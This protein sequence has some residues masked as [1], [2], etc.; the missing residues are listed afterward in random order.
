LLSPFDPLIHDRS[1]TRKVFGFDYTVEIFVPATK[2]KYGY[3]VLPI[4]EG[5]RFVGRIDLKLERKKSRLN[6][7]GVWWEK[8]VKA[9]VPRRARLGRQLERQARFAGVNEVSRF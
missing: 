8:G 5:E 3:Y 9:T 4:L 1:R 6:V 2:R 7:L